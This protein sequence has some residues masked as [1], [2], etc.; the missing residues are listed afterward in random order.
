MAP[1]SA[2]QIFFKRFFLKVSVM[3]VDPK[4]M[5]LA[6][7]YL[8]GKVEE[9]NVELEPLIANYQKKLS[10]EELVH[11]A[12]GPSMPASHQAEAPTSS[13]RRARVSARVSPSP[14]H[15]PH[16]PRIQCASPPCPSYPPASG[17]HRW[18]SRCSCCRRCASSW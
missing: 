8:A 15:P 14:H 5:M 9:E 13:A 4:K 18:R 10:P 17:A 6:A 16:D 11:R 1:Q 3:E 7:L 2:A 12:G